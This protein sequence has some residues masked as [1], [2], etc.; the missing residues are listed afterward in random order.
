MTPHINAPAGA[1]APTVLMPGDPLRAQFIAETF[2][3]GAE[4]V[5]NVR[6]MLGYTGHYKGRR[7]SVMAHGMGIP[8]CSIYS[9]ELISVYGV[10]NLIRVGTCGGIGDEVQLR[11]VVIGLSAST[12]SN[13]NRQRLFGYDYAATAD[14]AVVSALHRSA[15]ALRIPVRV[16]PL[17]SSDL[18]YHPNGPLNEAL[19][20]LRF[21]GIEMEAAGLFAVAQELGARAG[22]ICTVS[23]HV[24]RGD[25]TSPANRQTSFREMMSIALEAALLLED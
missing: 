25:S 11:D 1:F 15:E 16:G 7:L 2:L 5:S 23:D 17:F 18:F 21:L 3:E 14:F 10:K 9:H 20:R 12:D 19:R 24:I 6:N 4:Q 13:V 22:C 8:S